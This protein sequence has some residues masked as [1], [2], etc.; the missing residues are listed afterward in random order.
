M[1]DY[2]LCYSLF[3]WSIELQEELK[4]RGNFLGLHVIALCVLNRKTIRGYQS[5]IFKFDVQFHIDIKSG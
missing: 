4:K 1:Q 3:E 2:C 5:H